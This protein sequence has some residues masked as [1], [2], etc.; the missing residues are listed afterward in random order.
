MRSAGDGEPLRH[1][2]CGSPLE[3]RWWC[4]DCEQIV[5]DAADDGIVHL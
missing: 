3:A 2:V 4:P 1:T 5:D